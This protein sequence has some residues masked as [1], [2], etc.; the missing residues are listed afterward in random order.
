ME[1]NNSKIFLDAQGYVRAGKRA[2]EILK[3][4]FWN[5]I[6][7]LK[8]N[9]NE[10]KKLPKEIIKRIPVRFTYDNSYYFDKYEAMPVDGY[11]NIFKKLLDGIEVKLVVSCEKIFS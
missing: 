3:E 8:V 10:I 6:C 5:D 4:N 2:K 9:N 1:K 7:C 11:T